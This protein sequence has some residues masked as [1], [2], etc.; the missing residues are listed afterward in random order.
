[1]AGRII[2]KVTGL[3]HEQAV[4]K[5]VFELSVWRVLGHEDGCSLL[6]CRCSLGGPAS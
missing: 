3:T 2:E 1:V 5:L 4:T 6:G